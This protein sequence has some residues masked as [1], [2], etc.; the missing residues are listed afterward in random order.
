VGETTDGRAPRRGPASLRT[1][2][3]LASAALVGA[4]VLVPLPGAVDEPTVPYGRGLVIAEP[5]QSTDP[6]ADARFVL[7]TPQAAA[8][9]GAVDTGA[10][11]EAAGGAAAAA[12]ADDGP[13]GATGEADGDS[14]TPSPT[15]PTV[16]APARTAETTEPEEPTEP[17]ESTEPAEP[18]GPAPPVTSPVP[19]PGLVA[20]TLVRV[21]AEQLLPEGA[22]HTGEPAGEHDDAESGATLQAWVETADDAYR[23]SPAA[24]VGVEDGSTVTVELGA[25][26]AADQVHPVLALTDVRPPVQPADAVVFGAGSDDLFGVAEAARVHEVTV[27]LAVPKGATKDSMTASAVASSVTN[28][29]NTFWSQQS[30]GQRG[31]R[32]VASHSWQNLTSTCADAFKLWDEVAAKVGWTEAPRRHLLVYLPPSANCGAGLGTLGNGPDH[33]GRSWV[34]YN[35]TAIIAH[36]LGHNLGLGHSDGLLCSGRADGSY[37]TGT[38]QSGCTVS[39]YRDYYDIMGI[40]WQ[41]TGSLAAPHADA[42]G[43]LTSTE[44]LVTSDPV[45]VR[46]AP[47]TSD[48][49]RVLRIDDPAGTYYVEYRVATGWDSWLSN[50]WRGLDAGV[51]VHRRSPA[52]V[53]KTL[54]LDG[55]VT[56]GDRTQDWKSALKPGASLTTTSGRTKIVVESQSSTGATIVVHRD[57]VAPGTVTPPAGGAQVEIRTPTTLASA[58][59]TTVFSGVGTAPEGTLRWEVLEDGVRKAS[60]TAAAGSNGT[61]DAFSVPVALPAGTFTFRV[62]VPDDSD[63]EGSVDPAL[64][65]DETTL[66]LY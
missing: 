35:N 20:G 58:S 27:V 18:T 41:H 30:R 1:L 55:S 32:V 54:L 16:S 12:G 9:T 28:G 8:A 66:S 37:S 6:A 46:L 65:V 42:L 34:S 47:A 64:L 17:A 33:G 4:A 49:L 31:V 7:D 51:L 11:S 60:G 63:G 38:W 44:K 36:E 29:V 23:V 57:G 24:V 43:L 52:D 53:R 15:A 61:F 10:S 39:G 13:D 19:A 56:T 59:G 14:D 26:T 50:N 40:S 48:G 45:R 62:W 5:D 21:W 2:V 22:E 3:A 25:R